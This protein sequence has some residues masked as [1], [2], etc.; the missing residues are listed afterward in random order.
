MKQDGAVDAAI[1]AQ[2][3]FADLSNAQGPMHALK[4]WG[5][6]REA[7]GQAARVERKFTQNHHNHVFSQFDPVRPTLPMLENR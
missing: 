6:R 4:V 2:N 1:A 7:S 5:W 3:L